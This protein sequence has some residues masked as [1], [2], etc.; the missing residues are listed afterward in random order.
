[1]LCAGRRTA[2]TNGDGQSKQE[3]QGAQ[4]KRLWMCRTQK[5]MALA[6]HTRGGRCSKQI[7]QE[8]GLERRRGDKSQAARWR[9]TGRRGAAACCAA[10]AQ[11]RPFR[12]S[13]SQTRWWSVCRALPL[14]LLTPMSLLS[15]RKPSRMALRVG[16]RESQRRCV[17]TPHQQSRN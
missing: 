7:Q 12:R 16:L 8:S 4:Q 15:M 3:A 14:S 13:G 17:A 1:M 5:I 11:T 6:G 9:A 10:L 2:A